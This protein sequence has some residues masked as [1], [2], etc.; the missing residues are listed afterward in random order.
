MIVLLMQF[1]IINIRNL[2]S[3][4]KKVVKYFILFNNNNKKNILRIYLSYEYINIKI[5]HHNL[6]ICECKYCLIFFKFFY[7]S[8]YLTTF[9]YQALFHKNHFDKHTII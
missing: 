1:F 3:S 5:F 2:I 7:Y 8:K 4:D 6:R 9:L